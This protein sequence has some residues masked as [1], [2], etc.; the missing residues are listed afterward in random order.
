MLTRHELF[1]K[2]FASVVF[3]VFKKVKFCSP[4]ALHSPYTRN[5]QLCVGL[6]FIVVHM[7]AFGPSQEMHV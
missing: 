7:L 4:E 5:A 3:P 6:I 1:S 2:Q